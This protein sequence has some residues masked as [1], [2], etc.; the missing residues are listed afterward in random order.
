[1]LGG[2]LALPT[3]PWIDA[4]G[5]GDR[6]HPPRIAGGAVERLDLEPLGH[7]QVRHSFTHFD[8]TLVPVR[9]NGGDGSAFDVPE[10]MWRSPAARAGDGLPTLFRKCVNLLG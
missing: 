6:P 4:G 10:E 9:V 8:L 1:M 7:A 2:M 5:G 3:S